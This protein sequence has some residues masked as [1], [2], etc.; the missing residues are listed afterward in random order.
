M[1]YFYLLFI[2]FISAFMFC[3]YMPVVSYLG[4]VNEFAFDGV[5]LFLSVIP[6]FF[7]IFSGIFV[8]LLLTRRILPS[9]KSVFWGRNIS[10]S[11][12][13]VFFLLSVIILWVEGAFLSMDLPSITGEPDLF[14]SKQR[15]IFD[16][17]VWLLFFVVFLSLWRR[18]ARFIFH[19]FIALCLLLGA[20]L[21]DAAISREDKIPVAVG[22]KTVLENISF[23]PRENVITILADGFPSDVAEYILSNDPELSLEFDGFLFFRNNLATGGQ[24]TWAIPAMLQ[25]SVYEGGDYRT[26]AERVFSAPDSL[27]RNFNSFGYN[28]FISSNVARFC[29]VMDDHGYLTGAIAVDFSLPLYLQISFRFLPYAFK[30]KLESILTNMITGSTDNHN[31]AGSDSTVYKEYLIPALSRKS[32]RPT[33]HFHHLRGVHIPFKTDGRGNPLPKADSITETGLF[34]QSE[35]VLKCF[36]DFL[37][38]LKRQGLYDDAVIVLIADHGDPLGRRKGKLKTYEIPLFMVKPSKYNGGLIYSDVPFSNAY[39]THFLRML[40]NNPAD[41]EKF[42][43]NLPMERKIFSQPDKLFSVTGV[44]PET[45][46]LTEISIDISQPPTYILPDKKYTFRLNANFL[47]TPFAVPLQIKNMNP[48]RGRG[49]AYSHRNKDIGELKLKLNTSSKYVDIIFSIYGHKPDLSTEDLPCDLRITDLNSKN[50]YDVNIEI[51]KSKNI[52]LQ[53]V[54]VNENQEIIL[55]FYSDSSN[56]INAFCLENILFHTKP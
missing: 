28:I 39:L 22:H 52:I 38:A 37:R 10:V 46:D 4:N 9:E 27:I 18:F 42:L 51:R 41:L 43:Q 26:F 34:A 21:G 1:G 53:N 12:L 16:S 50:I 7:I 2:S 6:L 54:S 13:E 45:L 25:G 14:K 20:G 29:V 19:G 40:H 44:D 3:V 35:W 31:Y 32:V 15:F 56:N 24:T 8:L 49:I 55:S 33:V 36:A 48:A 23:H 47:V 17:A 30:W 11:P 5:S